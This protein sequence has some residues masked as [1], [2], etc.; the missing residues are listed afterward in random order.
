M[1]LETGRDALPRNDPE[2]AASALLT[3][4][5]LAIE[6]RQYDRA[7]NEIRTAETALRQDAGE[8]DHSLLVFAD[9]LGGVAGIRAG[10]VTEAVTR[11]AAQK[12]RYDRD[13]RVEANWV[14]ALE[15]EVALAQ[16]QLDRAAASFAAAAGRAWITLGR[17]TL[18]VFLTNPPSRDGPA[19]V[20]M[21]RGNRAAA[22]ELYRRLTAVGPGATMSGVLEP[23]HVLALARLLDQGGDPRGARVEYSRFLTLWA[24]ADRALPEIDEAHRAVARLPAS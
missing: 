3:S 14:A 12:A 21:A 8:P 7:L 11:L 6:R 18:I 16:G 2:A 1:V 23:L 20:E 9:L 10:N 5:W 22:I 15:G 19:R 24:S 4:S 13:D 17:D